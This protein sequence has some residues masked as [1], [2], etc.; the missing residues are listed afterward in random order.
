MLMRPGKPMPL[1]ITEFKVLIAGPGDVTSEL[2]LVEA[3]LNKWNDLHS[4]RTGIRLKPVRWKQARPGLN[5]DA[6][7]TINSQIV[8]GCDAGVAVFGARIGT[9]TPRMDSGTV[10]EIELLAANSRDV[11][12]YFFEGKKNLGNID[13]DQLSK[14]KALK[15]SLKPRGLLGAYTSLPDLVNQLDR[16]VISLGYMFADRVAASV[17]ATVAD[18]EDVESVLTTAMMVN[19]LKESLSNNRPIVT[20][21]LVMAEVEKVRDSL[22]YDG[23]FPVGSDIST[24]EIKQ[25]L[26]DFEIL[27]ER[28]MALMVEGG[29]WAERSNLEPWTS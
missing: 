2:K 24:E 19:A 3:A 23:S 10:E 26:P 21:D 20:H 27:S 17:Q 12:I 5:E 18:G 25:A 7:A 1:P 6:Q 28:L 9:M 22:E 16:H 8:D 13:P 29:R 11:M 4:E 15:A 14:V